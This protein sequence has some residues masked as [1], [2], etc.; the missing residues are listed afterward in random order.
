MLIPAALIRAPEPA[1]FVSPALFWPTGA[2]RA[3]SATRR[4][5]TTMTRRTSVI[6]SHI[7]GRVA[8]HRR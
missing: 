7:V 8:G 1:T 5:A 3:L 6:A 4:T 2:Q